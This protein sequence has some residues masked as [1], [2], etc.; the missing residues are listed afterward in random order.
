MP[1]K[2][3]LKHRLACDDI[4]FVDFIRWCLEIDPHRRPTAKEALNHPWFTEAS[5]PSMDAE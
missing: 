2:S 3:S 1:K 4:M 5:Y